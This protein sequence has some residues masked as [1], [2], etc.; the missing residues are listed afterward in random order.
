[1]R[2]AEVIICYVEDLE[3]HQ[4][5]IDGITVMPDAGRH[6]EFLKDAKKLAK[7]YKCE[8]VALGVWQS[9]FIKIV[10]ERK[11]MDIDSLGPLYNPEGWAAFKKKHKEKLRETSR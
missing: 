8:E 3:T 10:V 5:L 1:M 6:R 2:M 11:E 9:K 4:Q 7:T